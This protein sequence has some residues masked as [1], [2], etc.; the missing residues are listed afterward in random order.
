[1][2][3]RLMMIWGFVVFLIFA[4]VLII[5]F[6]KMDKV[7]LKLERDIKTST[8]KY[9]KDNNIELKF[10]KMHVITINDLITNEYLDENENIEKYCIKNIEITKGLFS[11]EYNIIKDCS[12]E[13]D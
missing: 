8:K 13:N 7:L 12:K 2:N 4:T 11:Y 1:M 9:V 10:N 5:G 6:N 3:K